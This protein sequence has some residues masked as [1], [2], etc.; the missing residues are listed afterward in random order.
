MMNI[1]TFYGKTFVDVMTQIRQEIGQEALILDSR[2]E[3]RGVAVTVTTKDNVSELPLQ[4]GGQEPRDAHLILEKIRQCLVH[5]NVTPELSSLILDHSQ[6]FLEDSVVDVLADSLSLHFRFLPDT[7]PKNAPARLMLI[8]APGVGKTTMAAKLS[9]LALLE[10]RKPKLLTVDS[11]KAGA[12]YQLQ[13]Y[14]QAM[15]IELKVCEHPTEFKQCLADLGDQADVIVDTPGIDPCNNEDVCRL[16]EL[17]YAWNDAP[18]LTMAAG[19]DPRAAGTQALE[20]T[21]FG[22]DRLIV[23][24]L[25]MVGYLGGIMAA[26]YAGRYGLMAMSQSPY[27]ARPFLSPRPTLF[28]KQLLSKAGLMDMLLPL[29]GGK[30]ERVVHMDPLQESKVA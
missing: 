1:R 15:G 21:K 27:I 28:A 11:L 7:F 9:A 23:T 8:G 26:A 4:K 14:A 17:V 18:V 3:K 13:T 30:E 6:V 25:D 20:F 2:V 12:I 29:Q 10:G 5:H 22:A 24:Q 19:S 16:A